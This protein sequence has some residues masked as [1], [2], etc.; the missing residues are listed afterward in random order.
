MRNHSPK[1]TKKAAQC[2]R[3]WSANAT[4]THGYT[5]GYAFLC[6]L[7]CKKDINFYK[8]VVDI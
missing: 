5:F 8:K 1:Q 4:V 2:V 7:Q 3:L 6:N